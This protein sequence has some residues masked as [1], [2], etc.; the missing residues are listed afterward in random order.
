MITGLAV[1]KD[2]EVRSDFYTLPFFCVKCIIAVKVLCFDTL[3]R[4]AQVL[5]PNN[6]AQVIPPTDKKE[7]VRKGEKPNI[8]SEICGTGN[9][10]AADKLPL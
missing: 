9:K 5:I 3:L 6:L 4:L 1:R 10:R 2:S 7:R 8:L